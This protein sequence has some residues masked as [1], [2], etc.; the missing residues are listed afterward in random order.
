[1]TTPIRFA[2]VGTNTISHKFAE[3]VA[4]SPCACVWAV[5]SRS[6]DTGEAFASTHHIETVYTDYEALL[7]NPDIDAVYIAT[8]N[9]THKAY[10][11]SALRAKKH[12]LCEK[13]MG[14]SLAEV[15]E[16]Q[17]CAKANGVILVEAMRPAFDVGYLEV[18]KQMQKLGRIRFAHLEF[19][20]YSSRYNAFLSGEVL[21]AF[22][23]TY[24][25]S[26]LMDIGV[27][28][29]H[30][31]AML[32]GQAR[33]ISSH[34]QFLPGGFEGMGQVTLSYTDHFVTVLYAKIVQSTLPSVI[35]GEKGSLHIDKLSEPTTLTLCL[36]G[37]K[38][39]K[40]PLTPLSNNMIYEVEVFC[41]GINH[42]EILEEI[43]QNSNL[44]FQ[45]IDEIRQANHITFGEADPL[46][47]S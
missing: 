21:R 24:G 33:A 18:K 5:C 46:F 42:P 43:N 12:V 6:K 23:Q 38:E 44:V 39:E 25:N 15:K 9:I 27:Y 28:P 19:C 10:T 26:A 37:E 2:I 1:M 34:S 36:L 29:L 47:N 8:P 45:W 31:C 32:F 3:A 13:P 11:L 22:N 14:I 16:M 20:Q 41:K 17:A 30:V 40:I 4:L 35:L 7:A